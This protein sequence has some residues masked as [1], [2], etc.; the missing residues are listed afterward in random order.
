MN[1]ISNNISKSIGILNN[2]K[3]VIPLKT[4]ILLY[5]SMILPRLNYGILAWRHHS[6]RVSKLQKKSITI[7]SLSKCNAHIEPIFKELK[8]LKIKDILWL[9]ELKFVL[10]I[11]KSQTTTLPTKSTITVK[12]GNS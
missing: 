4:K 10:Q 1:K 9:Q 5:N 8:L 11:Q 12:Y 2:I 7:L 3:R 6:E